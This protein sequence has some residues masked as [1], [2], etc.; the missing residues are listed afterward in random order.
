[1]GLSEELVWE[2]IE[3]KIK[4]IEEYNNN[5]L[6]YENNLKEILRD[7][8]PLSESSSGALFYL[9]SG[10]NLSNEDVK[11]IKDK[12]L[13]DPKLDSAFS[14][15]DR[16]FGQQTLGNYELSIEYF[17]K[18]IERNPEYSA[19]YAQRGFSYNKKN[20]FKT[21]IDDYTKAININKNW[22]VATNISLAYFD[23]GFAYIELGSTDITCLEKGIDDNLKVIE[24]N[25][26]QTTAYYN[27][28]IGYEK[29]QDYKNAVKWFIEAFEKDTPI[30]IPF[31]RAS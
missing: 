29:L 7:E 19:A 8:Y 13:N 3:K 10:L 4:K 5:L 25:P 12:I 14:W 31:I 27:I 2:I 18:A 23:R 28:A 24:L 21:A 6:E 1:M 16:G 17:T 11:L 9:Q 26:E 22:E 20:M 15:F 30:K